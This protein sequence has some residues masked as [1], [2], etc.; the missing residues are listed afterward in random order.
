MIK[1]E[2]LRR[3]LNIFFATFFND[4]PLTGA[5]AMTLKFILERSDIGNVY[6]KDVG[7]FLGVRGSSVVSLINYLE[8]NGYVTRQK[9]D[10][11]A[12]YKSIVPTERAFQIEEEIDRRLDDYCEKIYNGISDETLVKFEEILDQMKKNAE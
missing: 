4:L 5:Q 12:R 7:N 10:F 9:A 8:R 3:T 6:P 2:R 11:D 1:Q